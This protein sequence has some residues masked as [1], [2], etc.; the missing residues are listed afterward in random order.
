MN[1]LRNHRDVFKTGRE[2][3][4]K[5]NAAIDAALCG[6]N[7]APAMA[8][9]QYWEYCRSSNDYSCD[10]GRSRD[11]FEHP[12]GQLVCPHTGRPCVKDVS[13]LFREM[14]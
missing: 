5:G 10:C 7:Q 6:L 1:D 8:V 4:E 3:V 12:S 9:I 13:I 11:R 14:V 2:I